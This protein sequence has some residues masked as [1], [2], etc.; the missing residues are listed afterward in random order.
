MRLIL[1]LIAS[2]ILSSCSS[3]FAYR[4]LDWLIVWYSDDYLDLNRQQ[5]GVFADE[6]S[7]LLDWHTQSELPKYRSQLQAIHDDLNVLPLSSPLISQNITLIRTHWQSTREK[8]SEQL[9]PL[10][11]QLTSRQVDYLF[12]QLEERNQAR[13]TEYNELSPEETKENAIERLEET[14]INWLGSI[15]TVQSELIN[16]FIDQRHDTTLDRIRY[17]KVYQAH[18]RQVLSSPYEVNKLQALLNN[19]DAFKSKAYLKKQ[20][21]NMQHT[22]EFIRQLSVQLQPEQITHLQSKIMDYINTIDGITQS[23]Q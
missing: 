2:L 14:L 10:A 20:T 13:L 12:E 4:H 17:L 5:E 22:V 7:V 11:Q 21:S 1:I 6:V 23:K 8:L 15:N 9:A 3:G 19:P 18:L 16:A